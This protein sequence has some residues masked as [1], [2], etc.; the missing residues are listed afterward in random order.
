MTLA[1]VAK[2][3]WDA[4][5]FGNFEGQ[6]ILYMHRSDESVANDLGLSVDELMSKDALMQKRQTLHGAFGPRAADDG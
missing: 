1:R 5:R 4:T 6:N 3:Y 2:T